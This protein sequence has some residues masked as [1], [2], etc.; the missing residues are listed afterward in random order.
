MRRCLAV[1]LL[2]ALVIV[3]ACT[4][5]PRSQANELVLGAIYP[6]RAAGAGWQG[7][8]RRGQGGLKL[9][10]ATGAIKFP[11]ASTWSM[12]VPSGA[13]AAVDHLVRD[14]HVPAILSLRK[15][16]LRSGFSAG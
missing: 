14:G 15:H 6:L 1:P 2:V 13:A 5:S 7:R 12:Q 4:Q 3:T 11:C 9:A 10:Q 16:A 8:A